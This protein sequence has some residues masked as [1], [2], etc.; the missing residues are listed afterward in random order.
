MQFSTYQVALSF[1]GEE[2][3]RIFV[4]EVAEHLRAKGINVFFDEFE[5]NQ[6]WGK[7][8]AEVFNDVYEQRSQYVVM[9][10]SKEYKEGLW[11]N[12]ERRSALSGMISK[13]KEYIL[14]VRFDDTQLDGLP[15]DVLYPHALDYSPFELAIE[16]A[17]KLGVKPFEGKASHTPPPQKGEPTGQVIFNYS[18]YD[19]RYLIGQGT[20]TFETKWSRASNTSIYILNDP[21]TINGVALAGNV[22]NISAIK[23][24]NQCDFTSRTRC[25][26]LHEIAVLR[27]TNGIYAAIKIMKLRSRCHGDDRDEICFW[28]AIQFNGTADF[29]NFDDRQLIFT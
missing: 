1:A 25:P 13:K 17:K 16:I 18:N 9:F 6:L 15:G 8:G 22:E 26:Q 21:D 4:R 12:L 29:S 5:L 27:N 20:S 19:G 11:T 3:Q 14:P 7:N 24:A 23:D 10:I 2:S 28:Y